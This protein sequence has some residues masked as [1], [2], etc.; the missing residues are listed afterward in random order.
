[1]ARY[2]S[3]LGYGKTPSRFSDP[4]V[5]LREDERFGVFY[6]GA[7]IRVCF[8]ETVLRDRRTARTGYLPIPESELQEWNTVSVEITEALRLVDLTGDGPVRMGIPTDAGRASRHH[9]GQIWSLAL[10][11]H[12]SEPDGILFP[13]R[14]NTELNIALFDRAMPKI[15]HAMVVPL[16][17]QYREMADILQ[18]FELSIV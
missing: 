8:L 11:G 12:S 2:P 9:W 14:L 16:L 3:P 6:I 5:A 13:S 15:R 1:L 7:S 17:N 18:R 10:W 4:R